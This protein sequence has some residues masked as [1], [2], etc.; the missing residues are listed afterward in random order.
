MNIPRSLAA[1]IALGAIA[2]GAHALEAT[3]EGAVPQRIAIGE[4]AVGEALA[5]K[6]REYGERDVRQLTDTLRS[7]LDGAL[8]GIGRLAPEDTADAVLYVTIED[9]SPNRPTATQQT[10]SPQPMDHRSLFLGGAKVTAILRGADGETLGQFAYDWQTRPDVRH[11]EY[12]TTWTDARRTFQRF[13]KRLAEAIESERG[14][15]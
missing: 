7:D 14:T 10:A 15:S 8:G 9:A 12:A 13:A 11:S 4:I 2:A 1:I 3:F 6:T 5:A